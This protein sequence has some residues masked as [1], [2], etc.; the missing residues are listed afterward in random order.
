MGSIDAT[1]SRASREA[2]RPQPNPGENC[3]I[4]EPLKLTKD[5]LLEEIEKFKRKLGEQNLTDRIVKALK[6]VADE[7]T[8]LAPGRNALRRKKR[9]HVSSSTSIGCAKHSRDRIDSSLFTTWK[10]AQFHLR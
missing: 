9:L 8:N 1:Q 4:P 5:M 2:C 6:V 10:Q 7:P 3:E